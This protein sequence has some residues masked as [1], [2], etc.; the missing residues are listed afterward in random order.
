MLNHFVSYKLTVEDTI[1][2]FCKHQLT[3][4][5]SGMES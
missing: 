2:I 4:K 5:S 3:G 1:N